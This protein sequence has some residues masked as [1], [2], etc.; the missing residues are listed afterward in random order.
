MVHFWP[1]FGTPNWV[2][3]GLYFWG[4]LLDRF[5]D[6][7]WNTLGAISG[8]HF[9]TRSAQEG[10]RWDQEGH[11]SFKVPKPCICKILKH[12][13]VFH[14]FWGRMPFKTAWEGPRRLP[15]S[16]RRAPKSRNNGSNNGLYFDNFLDHFWHRL[17]SIVGVK[18]GS[19]IAP[20]MGT[21]RVVAPT[22]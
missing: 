6:T 2:I 13:H 18:M 9:G 12:L 10:P 19:Q 17:G 14:C 15:R 4:H 1:G 22:S 11:Q 7:F 20:K 8:T 21:Q 16:T 3:L 5:L